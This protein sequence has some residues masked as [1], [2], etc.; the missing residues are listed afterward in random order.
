VAVLGLQITYI[1][2]YIYIE[3]LVAFGRLCTH[4]LQYSV[5]TNTAN[6]HT[7]CRGRCTR[8]NAR[9]QPFR[10][11]WDGFLPICVCKF[12]VFAIW[13]AHINTTAHIKRTSVTKSY[14]RGLTNT[15]TTTIPVRLHCQTHCTSQQESSTR[16]APDTP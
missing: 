10:C 1:C 8:H 6:R 5:Q 2:I 4:P 15:Y 9:I 13:Y 7:H 12:F 3:C 14:M 16:C 11:I